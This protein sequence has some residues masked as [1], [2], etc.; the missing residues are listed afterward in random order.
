MESKVL[1]ITV[2][3]GNSPGQKTENGGET[4]CC[5]LFGEIFKSQS[6]DKE[7]EQK[8]MEANCLLNMQPV[9]YQ[10]PDDVPEASAD[11]ADTGKANEI[12]LLMP[13]EPAEGC[14]SRLEGE[15]GLI[16]HV[17]QDFK[18]IFS[19][20]KFPE[21][22]GL[23]EESDK[24]SLDVIAFL[25]NEIKETGKTT[26]AG[27]EDKT[28]DVHFADKFSEDAGNNEVL[29]LSDEPDDKNFN[30][31]FR[32][33]DDKKPSNENRIILS[34]KE[35]DVPIIINID[36]N[37][38][39]KQ[40]DMK[41]GNA[42]AGN[43]K[44]AVSAK[45][46]EKNKAK[47]SFDGVIFK[48]RG[49]K[50]IKVLPEKKTP[51]TR[52]TSVDTGISKMYGDF[53][54]LQSGG[55]N[56]IDTAENTR[57]LIDTVNDK[58]VKSMAFTEADGSQEFE[59]QLKPEFLGKLVIKLLK[60]HGGMKVKIFTTSTEVKEMLTAGTH[61]MQSHI[62]ERGVEISDVEIIY[63]NLTGDKNMTEGRE[64]FEKVNKKRNYKVKDDM[65]KY[66]QLIPE[67]ESAAKYININGT[68]S[69]LV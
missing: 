16:G 47:A 44:S 26:G 15:K 60:D 51:D 41:T 58:I 42:G 32:E 17:S 33:P 43:G 52:D 23:P 14:D 48:S 3:A 21:Q 27:F 18:E 66:T 55:V 37:E 19:N 4:A 53:I 30:P 6:E 34:T 31:V 9:V 56:E 20:Q 12:E 69:Y 39:V 49:D 35:N 7:N 28:K 29:S 64:R 1:G 2:N 13:Q 54:E 25:K 68:V 40:K 38:T 10:V 59:L 65:E 5:E 11:T 46:E 63:Q 61:F 50:N 22:T 45:L 8:N 57:Q 36:K 67:G 24:S 62:Q